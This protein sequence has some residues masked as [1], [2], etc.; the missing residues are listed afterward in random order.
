MTD[1]FILNGLL[2]DPADPVFWIAVAVVFLGGGMRGF[3]GF[4]SA[5]LF[6][7]VFAVMASPAHM[8]PLVVTLEFPI[9]VMLFMETRRQADWKFVV[10]MAIAAI[11]AMPLG[12]WLLVSVD[13]RALT[14][15]ISV[16][17]L[18]FVGL[19]MTG[20]RYRGPRPLPLTFGIGAASGAMMATSSVGGP[21]IL[22]YMLA[23]DHPAATIRANVVSYFFVTLFV[24]MAMVFWASP[25]A[26][27]AVIDGLV[28]CPATLIGVWLGSR[29]AGRANDQ[30]Y[31]MIC[32][33]FI[34]VAAV[35]GL[36][37]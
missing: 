22:L 15:G 19:L 25:T 11:I 31:R 20:W 1:A 9:G 16:A 5:M 35:I 17:I 24:L 34:V 12:I 4:G 2:N 3:A 36:A 6:A 21:P 10:P 13:Q 33:G 32:Y 8:V 28:L 37:G 14:I 30:I 29:M 23:A 18:L 27:G 26:L 7:P